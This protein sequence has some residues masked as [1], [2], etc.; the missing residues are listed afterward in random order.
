MLIAGNVGRREID[1]PAYAHR[2]IMDLTRL[3]ETKVAFEA[4]C[5]ASLKCLKMA[6]WGCRTALLSTAS[7]RGELGGGV[8]WQEGF[9]G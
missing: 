9:V 8:G 1:A 5:T 7:S 6:D 3:S 4:F 2:V